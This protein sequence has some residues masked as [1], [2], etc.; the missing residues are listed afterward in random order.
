MGR[1]RFDANECCHRSHQHLKIAD[2]GLARR[3][4]QLPSTGDAEVRRQSTGSGLTPMGQRPFL[5]QDE[6]DD[7][8]DDD[9]DDLAHS[10]SYRHPMHRQQKQQQHLNSAAICS[11]GGGSMRIANGRR[12]ASQR[13]VEQSACGTPHYLAPEM[14]AHWRQLPGSGYDCKCDVPALRPCRG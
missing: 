2:F 14:I 9:D 6:D 5:Y 11:G 13:A 3:L 4:Q 7:D 12:Q 8:E 10:A 1:F